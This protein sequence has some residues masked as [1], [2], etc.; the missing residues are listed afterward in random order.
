MKILMTGITGFI[1]HHL[2]E[3]L[4]NDGHEVHAIVRPT[5]K[6]HELSEN[7]RANVKFHVHDRENTLLDIVTDLCV[8]NNRP[9]VIFHLATNFVTAHRFEDIQ[10]LIQSNIT[11]GTE[12]LDAMA[13]NNIFNFVNAG[14]FEQTI[15]NNLSPVNLYAA[16]K[17][18]FEG[19]VNFYAANCGLKCIGL[20]LSDV[21]ATDD[22]S[23]RV[24]GRLR[25]SLLT[26]EKIELSHSG[27]LIDL[28]YIDDA[29]ESFIA[30]Q[31]ILA[32]N[33]Y[34]YCG[35][36]SVGMS[37][38]VTLGEVVKIFEEVSGKKLS[39]KWSGRYISTN[40]RGTPRF[41]PNWSPTTALRDGIKK[42]LG[43]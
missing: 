23:D 24:L 31:K 39:I 14:T 1:G 8:E 16:T 27:Q 7:L 11:F 17:D 6:V 40:F 33:K 43:G 35:A 30:A 4:V 34:D 15:D 13:A 37:R 32:A 2:G 26:G 28:I 41:L 5:S 20:R 19:I 29:V 38:P 10:K 18:C 36:Y 21:Y 3:R 42:F 25:R 22:K 9:D 12:L